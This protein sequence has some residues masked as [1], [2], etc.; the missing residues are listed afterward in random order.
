MPE[1]IIYNLSMSTGRRAYDLLRGYV[2]RE[3]E[4]IQGVDDESAE[5]ELNEALEGP[6]RRS[7]AAAAET[8]YE[9]VLLSDEEKARKILGVGSAAS[10]DEIKKAFDRL[11]ERSNPDHFPSGS[12][13]AEHAAEIRSRVY[14]AYRILSDKFDSTETRFKSLEID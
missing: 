7:S 2:N 4:R 10:F 12:A 3:W 14:R 8:D 13:E 5:R 11:S 9:V 1:S 6:L